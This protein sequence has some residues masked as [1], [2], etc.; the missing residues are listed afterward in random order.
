MGS[1]P[2]QVTEII[3]V[4]GPKVAIMLGR[5]NSTRATMA[6]LQVGIWSEMNVLRTTLAKHADG[7]SV[8]WKALGR[9]LERVLEQWSKYD[10]LYESIVGLADGIETDAD[11]EAHLTFQTDLFTL[12]DEVQVVV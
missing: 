7:R 2:E 6:R 11:K 4:G 3:S 1:C 8:G 5:I 10:D 12:R 9:S